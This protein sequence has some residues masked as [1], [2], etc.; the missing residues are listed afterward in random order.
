MK[1]KQLPDEWV[2]APTDPDPVDDLGYR[3]VQLDVFEVEDGTE[4]YMILPMCEDMLEDEAF[5]VA[6][7]D[8]VHDLE[9]R[10]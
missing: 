2:D 4:R 10:I 5:I 7:S 9:T 6:D 1:G 3:P 8:A